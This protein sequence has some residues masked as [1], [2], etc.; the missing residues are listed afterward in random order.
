[1]YV[2]AHSPIWGS[3]RTQVLTVTASIAIWNKKKIVIMIAAGV[4]GINVIFLIQGEPFPPSFESSEIPF[5][6]AMVPAIVR[7]NN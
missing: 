1:M 3:D 4:W 6:N 2:P 5:K 7:V